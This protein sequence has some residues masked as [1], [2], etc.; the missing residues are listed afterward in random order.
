MEKRASKFWREGEPLSRGLGR[1]ISREEAGLATRY[2]VL[3]ISDGADDGTEEVW[4]SC[5]VGVQDVEASLAYC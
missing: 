3:A 5:L 2:A 4:E 1:V